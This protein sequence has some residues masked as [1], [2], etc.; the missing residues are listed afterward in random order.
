[1]PSTGLPA[2]F[3]AAFPRLPARVATIT[4][5]LFLRQIQSCLALSLSLSLAFSLDLAL[6]LALSL[7]LPVALSRRAA[8]ALPLARVVVVLALT[9]AIH[10]PSAD[11]RSASSRRDLGLLLLP[12]PH[13]D[14][15]LLPNVL[16]YQARA[17]LISIC[18]ELVFASCSSFTSAHRTFLRC[19]SAFGFLAPPSFLL[20]PPPPPFLRWPPAWSPSFLPPSVLAH[21]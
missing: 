15:A 17:N 19:I 10:S 9:L 21:V 14:P 7:A 1:M 16:L 13:I 12:A 8:G 6:S 5:H 20:P 2:L 11:A 18:S 4:L 3:A